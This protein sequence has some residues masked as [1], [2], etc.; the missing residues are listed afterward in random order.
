MWSHSPAF[1][2][3]LQD[4]RAPPSPWAVGEPGSA[5][6]C[7]VVVAV[8]ALWL[9]MVFQ[10]H[11]TIPGSTCQGQETQRNCVEPELP[12]SGLGSLSENT[13]PTCCFPVARAAGT[14]LVPRPRRGEP[15]GR[16]AAALIFPPEIRVR[17]PSL[18]R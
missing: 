1:V 2:L 4:P 6:S 5:P 14:C 16:W 9:H 10:V 18:L 3:M 13:R 17:V 11:G 8:A 12:R 7:P 15:T